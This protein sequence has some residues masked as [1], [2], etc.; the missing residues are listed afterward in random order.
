MRADDL[1]YRRFCFII[2]RAALVMIF[3]L[4]V[5][6]LFREFVVVV[7]GKLLDMCVMRISSDFYKTLQI[8]ILRMNFIK[9]KKINWYNILEY[10]YESLQI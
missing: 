4:I 10:P 7:A 9:N 3:C 2:K 1:P 5:I 6:Y 8:F